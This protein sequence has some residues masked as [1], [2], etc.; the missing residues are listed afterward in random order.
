MSLA[1][2]FRGSETGVVGAVARHPGLAD[3]PVPA[4]LFVSFHRD[5]T[6]TYNSV[7]P[8]NSFSNPGSGAILKSAQV[9][10]DGVFGGLTANY[11]DLAMLC[12]RHIIGTMAP[13]HFHGRKT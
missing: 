5:L 7:N 11:T 2:A 13:P 6:A 3:R 8:S 9:N 10:S 4:G 1:F 12:A